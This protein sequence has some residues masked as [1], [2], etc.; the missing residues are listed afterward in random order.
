MTFSEELINA[1]NAVYDSSLDFIDRLDE[2]KDTIDN[3]I[4]NVYN[5]W[6]EKLD[7]GLSL[8]NEYVN[9]SKTYNNLIDLVSRNDSLSADDWLKGQ[10]I[11]INTQMN[12]NKAVWENMASTEKDLKTVDDKITSLK[13]T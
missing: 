10:K 5:L 11:I 13:E 12:V 6:T 8:L 9:L 2:I 7:K 3:E 4:L 1:L